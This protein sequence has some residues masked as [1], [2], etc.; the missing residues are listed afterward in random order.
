MLYH[1]MINR[2]VSYILE[3]VE[4]IFQKT[5]KPVLPIIQVKD[6]PDNL[7]DKLSGEEIKQAFDEARKLPALGVSFF[8]WDHAVE[9][10]KTELIRK[11]FRDRG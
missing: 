11:L 9:K 6:M 3:Y 2:P 7:P 8:S 5:K 4:W 1:R 10:G